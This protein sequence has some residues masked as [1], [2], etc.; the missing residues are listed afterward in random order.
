MSKK[1]NHF[2]EKDLALKIVSVFIGILIWFIVLDHQNPLGERTVSVPLRSNREIL[3]ENNISLVSSTLPTSVDVV[4]RGRK[5]RIE[6]VSS[7][8]FY[9]FLDFRHIENT[10]TTEIP[11]P[12]PQYN[13]DQD[14]SV[15]DVYPKNVKIQL[16]KIIRKEFPVDI[17][18][19]GELPEGYEAVHVKLNPNTVILE[20]LESV[21]NSVTS[22][23]VAVEREQLFK[24]NSINKRIEVYNENGKKISTLDGSNQVTVEYSLAKAVP[25]TTTLTGK[26]K[27]DFYVKDSVLSQNSVR[28]VGNYDLIRDIAEIRA[29]PVNVEDADTSFQRELKLQIPENVQLYNNGASITAQVNIGKFSHKM[30][31]IPK[32]SITI[33]GGDVTGKI[34]YRILEEE[35]AFS[36]K[37]PGE[38]LDILDDKTIKGF[39]DVSEIGDEKNK[40][41]ISVSLPSG[42]NLDDKVYVT[43]ET[44]AVLS[45]S[46]TPSHSP[47]PAPTPAPGE[48][49]SNTGELPESSSP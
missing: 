24:G 12:L 21:M 30:V 45:I 49:D 1:F 18:W 32:S 14:I 48:S 20:E 29:E 28:I 7:N 6:K 26:P 11:L 43:I 17:K 41:E 22:V 34:K 5:Q 10:E 8:D 2:F 44:E 40:A 46:P 38:I 3:A 42:I 15:L 9:A 33:F 23:S 36:V 39:V 27:D 37:G 13:G 16:E 47:T 31:S 19:T 25:V 4:I 35:V